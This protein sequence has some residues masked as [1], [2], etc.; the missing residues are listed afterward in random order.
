MGKVL[1]ESFSD[2]EHDVRQ[3]RRLVMVM[4]L[5]YFSNAGVVVEDYNTSRQ[6]DSHMADFDDQG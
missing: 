4:D 5:H 1:Y 3:N 2:I 6:V